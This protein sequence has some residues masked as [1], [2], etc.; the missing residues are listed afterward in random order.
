M[1]IAIE[2]V[3]RH[4]RVEQMLSLPCSLFLENSRPKKKKDPIE[5]KMVIT[6]LNGYGTNSAIARQYKLYETKSADML[7]D[8]RECQLSTDKIFTSPEVIIPGYK[9]LEFQ[10]PKFN[11]E[12]KQQ[13]DLPMAA[14]QERKY[15]DHINSFFNPKVMNKY[16]ENWLWKCFNH[17][18][19]KNDKYGYNTLTPAQQRDYMTRENK[20]SAKIWEFWCRHL[21]I[22]SNPASE[23]V[24][25]RYYSSS[26]MYKPSK[27]MFFS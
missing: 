26:F 21:L 8:Y 5:G 10:E 23:L 9:L 13:S 15:K 18:Y 3:L 4:G 20:A 6:L 1:N 12:E 19:M 7:P 14:I 22:N 17:I 2:Y 11:S 27:M 25:A 24:F 16:R